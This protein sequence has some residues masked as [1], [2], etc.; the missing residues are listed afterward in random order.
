MTARVLVHGLEGV[1]LEETRTHQA[2]GRR[3]AGGARHAPR[4]RGA[5]SARKTRTR[6]R[7]NTVG[8]RRPRASVRAQSAR[9]GGGPRGRTPN[10]TWRM[11]ETQTEPTVNWSLVEMRIELRFWFTLRRVELSTFMIALPAPLTNARRSLKAWLSSTKLEMGQ[12]N[13]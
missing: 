1:N 3:S 6:P 2:G 5:I 4:P 11:S 10:G 8:E 7:L 12:G 13:A 9:W